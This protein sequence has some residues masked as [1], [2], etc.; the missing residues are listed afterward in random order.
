MGTGK[1]TVGRIIAER[2]GYTF[3]DTDEIIESRFGPIS[4]IFETQGEPAF[5][6]MERDVS[7]EL[8]AKDRY[9]ISTGG[10]LMLGSGCRHSLE[11]H[12]D[13]VCLTAEP[14]TILERVTAQSD[15]KRPLLGKNPL[16]TLRVALQIRAPIY[17]RYPSVDTT[18]RSPE[19]VAE[20]VIELLG[21]NG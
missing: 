14:E 20:A 6:D 7:E 10:G 17:G 21:Y 15:V 5:R 13:V 4:E 1:T 18:E 11:P 9:V 12:A 19:E 8:S 3:V 2:I 16:R